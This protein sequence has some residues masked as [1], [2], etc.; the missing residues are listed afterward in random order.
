MD[1]LYPASLPTAATKD[2]STPPFQGWGPCLSPPR[3]LENA[4]TQS[5]L[6]DGGGDTMLPW[7]SKDWLESGWMLLVRSAG[8]PP[9]RL[10][11]GDVR[12]ITF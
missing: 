5:L 12:A 6:A 10:A 11:Y 7:P 1:H 4:V 3:A 2:G 9:C 8:S